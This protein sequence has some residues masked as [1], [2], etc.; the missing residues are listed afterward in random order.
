[1]PRSVA[2]MASNT[3][4]LRITPCSVI[5]MKNTLLIFYDRNMNG[6]KN[7]YQFFVL[8]TSHVLHICQVV[9]SQTAYKL[10]MCFATRYPC[11]GPGQKQTHRESQCC[12]P[13]NTPHFLE[14]DHL[15]HIS[16]WCFITLQNTV[17]FTESSNTNQWGLYLTLKTK[18]GKK[19]D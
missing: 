15:Q 14:K 6:V 2:S 9:T 4:S 1:M 13:G 16:R 8:G 5:Q 7:N 12:Q 10:W 19:R 17:I 11:H 18:W 3:R